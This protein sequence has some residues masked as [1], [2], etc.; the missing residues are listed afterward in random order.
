MTDSAGLIPD[1]VTAAFA[2][3]SEALEAARQPTPA[4]V[5]A[6]RDKLFALDER[7][8]GRAG[9]LSDC[10][11]AATAPDSRQRSPQPIGPNVSRQLARVR[12]A[13]SSSSM[14]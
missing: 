2:D 5:E 11:P 1:D 13:S 7:S 9:R 6:V 10:L 8:N 12:L 4:R 14:D 3:L